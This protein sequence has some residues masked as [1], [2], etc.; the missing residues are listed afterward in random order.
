MRLKTVRV[1]VN[2]AI[3]EI[4]ADQWNSLVGSDC[5][6]LRHE[7]LLAA[8][9]SGSVSPES[10]WI[11]RHLTCS[12]DSNRLRAALV[13]YEKNHSWGE[14]VFDWAWADAYS[15]AGFDYYPKLVSAAPFTP[16]SGK[17]LLLRDPADTEATSALLGAA[18]K[19]AEETDCSSVHVLFPDAAH[20][21][22][23]QEAGL[24]VRK[25]C[26]FHWYN[27]DYAHF[28]DF[29]ATF[30]SAKRKKTRRDRR[31][32]AEAGISFRHLKGNDLDAA[33]WKIVYR[34][35]SITF[36]RRGSLPYFNLEFFTQLGRTMPDNI[37][38]IL[39]ERDGEA[40]AASLFFESDTVLY[41]RYW[42]SNGHYDALHFEACY[43]QGIE[44]CIDTGKQVFE[45]GTQGEH[46]ISRGF[47]P[48]PTWSAHWLKHAEFFS[49][50]GDYLT[51]ER[52]HVERYM[53]AVDAHSPYRRDDRQG[54]T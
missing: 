10:G 24:H 54:D 50:I 20:L 53:E 13:L 16:A 8:E 2:D 33:A 9:Q 18:I 36:M 14:F 45:P 27:R 52:R 34:L 1:E 42:G 7:F 41:G 43:Y 29:L 25:G 40:V 6:F 44:Y 19:L 11:P 47:V 3:G 26:Q 51:E 17:R 49:A 22:V 31:R 46:K 32:V 28:D 38:V 15:Q 12:D 30:S 35:I 23:L 5:P 48:T 37:L 4:A 39:A 21:P